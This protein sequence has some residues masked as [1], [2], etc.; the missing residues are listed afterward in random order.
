[1]AGGRTIPTNTI[2][3]EPIGSQYLPDPLWVS[4]NVEKGIRFSAGRRLSV[5]ANILNLL[6]TNIVVSGS[7]YPYNAGLVIQSGATFMRTTDIAFPRMGEIV[8]KYTF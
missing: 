6:N 2:R 8:V 3:V 5:A 1:M 7:A 4:L